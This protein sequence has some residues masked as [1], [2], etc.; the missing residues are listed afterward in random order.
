MS[1]TSIA[2]RELPADLDRDRLPNHV[3]VIMDGNGRWAQ[4]RKLPRIMG[5]QRGA[6]T[7]HELVLCCKDWGIQSLT[8][9][10]F[11]TENWRRPDKEVNFLMLLIEQMLRR[12]MRFMEEEKVRLRVI[13]NLE[14]LPES[15]QHEVDQAMD[16][17]AH[18]DA[19]TLNL[20]ANY[21]GRQEI[22]HACRQLA[23]QVQT[24]KI[25]PEEIDEQRLAQVLY[26]SGMTDPDLLIRT[27]GEMRVSNFLLWQLAYAEFYVTDTLWPDFD[28]Q[29][30]HKA[31]SAYQQR[32]RRYGKVT[33]SAI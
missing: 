31:L 10:A 8:V 6:D 25:A 17:T 30:F 3:A 16:R 24:G 11:S 12:E 4:K 13:G 22:V 20:A 7:L 33:G 26:T 28:R 2:L 18:H 15:L 5:H 29:E 1:A 23:T 21:G 19:L 32:D 14:A 9:Y 27:S